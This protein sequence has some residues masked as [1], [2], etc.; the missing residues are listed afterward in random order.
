LPDRSLEVVT[1]AIVTLR[2]KA[3]NASAAA[4]RASKAAAL[5]R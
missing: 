2:G 1:S 3:A 4:S 5:L